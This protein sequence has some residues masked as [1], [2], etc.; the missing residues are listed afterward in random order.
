MWDARSRDLDAVVDVNRL[1]ARAVREAADQELVPVVLAGNCNSCIGTLAGLGGGDRIGIV[2]LDAHGDFNTPD[3]S[4]SGLLEGMSLAI[5][6]GL[7]HDD[8]RIRIGLNHVVPGRNVVM[9]GVRDL[10]P[11]EGDRLAMNQVSVRPPDALRDLMDLMIALRQRADQI[12]LHID[13]DFLDP[14][15]SPGTNFRA[16]NGVS[17]AT[18]KDLLNSIVR[19]VP[20]SAVALTNY[21]PDLD[22]DGKSA[23]AALSLLAALHPG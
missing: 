2:W 13:L 15:E 3:T 1:I 17:V 5:A 18:G 21:N 14:L 16:G 23:Q 20:V 10:D 22:E 11:G 4:P 6:V 12:Y 7:C 19:T 9:V 8:L